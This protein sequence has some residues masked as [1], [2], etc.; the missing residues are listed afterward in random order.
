MSDAA[1]VKG[2]GAAGCTA[3]SIVKDWLSFM[4]K[5]A[6]LDCAAIRSVESKWFHVSLSLKYVWFELKLNIINPV[7]VRST[8]LC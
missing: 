6:T 1:C 5:R 3:A 7:F 4:S 8:Y 2:A